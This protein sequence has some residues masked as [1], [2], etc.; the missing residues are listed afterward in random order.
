MTKGLSRP[1]LV[2]KTRHLA[3]ANRSCVSCAQVTKMTLN[4]YKRSSEISRL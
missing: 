4:D 2:S 1:H 3:I